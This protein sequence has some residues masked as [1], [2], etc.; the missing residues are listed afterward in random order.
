MT[1]TFW[2]RNRGC[3]DLILF[4]PFIVILFC[5]VAVC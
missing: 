4:G 2:N 3:G 1:E 5:M